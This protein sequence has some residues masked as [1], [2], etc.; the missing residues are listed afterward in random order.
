MVAAAVDDRSLS[1]QQS[2]EEDR[3]DGRVVRVVVLAGPVDVEEPED[4]PL[5]AAGAPV[6][7]QQVLAREL[8]E[9]VRG[10]RV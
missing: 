2:L 9:A 7:L 3:R 10:L 5:K 8:A 6:E 1:A 4:V